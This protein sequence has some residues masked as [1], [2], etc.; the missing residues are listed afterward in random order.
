M[1]SFVGTLMWKIWFPVLAAINAEGKEGVLY[2]IS[3]C[4]SCGYNMV[5]LWK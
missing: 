4:P 1:A 3:K 5:M 2:Q